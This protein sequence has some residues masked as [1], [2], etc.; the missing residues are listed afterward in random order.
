VGAFTLFARRCY[1]TVDL[2]TS[3][4]QNGFVFIAYSEPQNMTNIKSLITLKCY[5]RAAVKKDH[6]TTHVVV[7]RFVL[8]TSENPPLCS[9][10]LYYRRVG[11][12]QGKRRLKRE[13]GRRKGREEG[14]Y[15]SDIGVEGLTGS[16]DMRGVKWNRGRGK[17]EQVKTKKC[18]EHG[19]PRIKSSLFG[20]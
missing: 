20:I 14:R 16:N 12:G 9:S 13:A 8:Q 6:N 17:K 18:Q 15:R 7:Y 2:E 3:M 19:G 5:H 4:S 1:L 10:T 11:T